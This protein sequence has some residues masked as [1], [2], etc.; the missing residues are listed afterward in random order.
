MAPLRCAIRRNQDSF[1]RIPKKI[2]VPNAGS[3]RKS[4]LRMVERD[5]L[6]AHEGGYKFSNPFFR[7]WLLQN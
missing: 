5:I 4:V 2:G 1:R 6:Y 7:V 3:I